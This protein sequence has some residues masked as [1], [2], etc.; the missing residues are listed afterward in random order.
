MSLKQN[1]V[2]KKFRLYSQSA[3]IGYFLITINGITYTQT[4]KD[5][6]STDSIFLLTVQQGNE[7]LLCSEGTEVLLLEHSIQNFHA[8]CPIPQM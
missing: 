1:E 3:N 5:H 2:F 8:P 4:L 6:L 7:K